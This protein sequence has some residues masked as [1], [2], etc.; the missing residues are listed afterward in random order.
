M[1]PQIRFKKIS[2]FF[3][4]P[5]FFFFVICL[6]FQEQIYKYMILYTQCFSTQSYN[7]KK[8][9]FIPFEIQS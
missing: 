6:F 2:I 5:A 9:V 1:Q 4:I 3:L 7:V 8:L